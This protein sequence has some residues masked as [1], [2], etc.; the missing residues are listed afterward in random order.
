MGIQYVG[1]LDGGAVGQVQEG[2]PKDEEIGAPF[3]SSFLG[4]F[5]DSLRI[6]LLF[7]AITSF[8]Q[9]ISTLTFC[10]F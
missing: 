5:I 3:I 6:V 1:V 7:S 2:G 8:S 9:A 10:I 4:V